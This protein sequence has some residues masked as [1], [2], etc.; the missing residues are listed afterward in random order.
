MIENS[1]VKST[2]QNVH[3]IDVNWRVDVSL[4]TSSLNRTLEPTVLIEIHLSNGRILSFEMT[5]QSFHLLRFNV[6]LVLKEMDDILNRQIFKL[7]D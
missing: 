4:S 1:L 3:V 2:P 6:A 5:L 7:S